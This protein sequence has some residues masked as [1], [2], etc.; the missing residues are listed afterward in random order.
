MYKEPIL[1][2]FMSILII[3]CNSN[4][5]TKTTEFVSLEQ[6]ANLEY[7]EINIKNKKI[8]VTYSG[9]LGTV[10]G[11]SGYI[12]LFSEDRTIQ[13]VALP[14]ENSI[15]PSGDSFIV[16]IPDIENGYECKNSTLTE[17]SSKKIKNG[18]AYKILGKACL[19]R[20]SNEGETTDIEMYIPESVFGAGS[21]K[22]KISGDKAYLNTSYMVSDD[23]IVDGGLGTRAYNQIF[24]LIQQHPEVKTII[25]EQISGSINDE[26]NMQTGRL[27]RKAGLNTHIT[28]NSFIA[29]GAADLFCAGTK[30]TMENGAEVGVHSWSDSDGIE[31]GNLPEDSPLHKDQIDYFTEMLGSPTGK[32]FYFYTIEAA[33]AGEIYQMNRTEME[34]YHLL[35]E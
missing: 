16:N 5:N 30:R 29:S 34:E 2:T 24:D 21:S 26:I 1:L 13:I 9:S 20:G 23:I 10:D 15:T 33:S 28:E 8:N 18:K 32:K 35:T 3:G 31:A 14:S 4:S 27:V 22:L 11:Y 25:E 12:G 19:G 17:T 6:R 7:G